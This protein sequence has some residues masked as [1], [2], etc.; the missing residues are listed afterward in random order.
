MKDL[1]IAQGCLGKGVSIHLPTADDLSHRFQIPA[2][3]VS[4]SNP[5]LRK[6]EWRGCR[7]YIARSL[8]LEFW[9]R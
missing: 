3:Q 9:F 8:L 4:G 6:V 7:R 5:E 2:H 1:R